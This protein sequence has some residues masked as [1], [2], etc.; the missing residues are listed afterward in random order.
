MLSGSS[1]MVLYRM[2]MDVYYDHVY[3]N[4]SSENVPVIADV[5]EISFQAQAGGCSWRVGAF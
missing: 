5:A 4:L 3:D 2:R 1:V